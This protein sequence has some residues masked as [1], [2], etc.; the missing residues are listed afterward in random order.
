MAHFT[1]VD[2]FTPTQGHKAV[3]E[4]LI[5]R[6]HALDARIERA[7]ANDYFCD[8]ADEGETWFASMGDERA[9]LLA[10]IEALGYTRTDGYEKFNEEAAYYRMSEA[11]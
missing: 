4:G 8:Y 5:S 6:Y 10:A 2:G 7:L 9:A 11:D 1:P 3:V